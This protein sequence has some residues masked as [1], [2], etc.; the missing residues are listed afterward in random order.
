MSENKS[1]FNLTFFQLL[2]PQKNPIVQKPVKE[3]FVRDNRPEELLHGPSVDALPV[4]GMEAAQNRRN[5]NTIDL[6]G[7]QLEGKTAC[8]AKL[9]VAVI[10]SVAYLTVSPPSPIFGGKGGSHRV[11]SCRRLPSGKLENLKKLDPDGND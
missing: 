11:K 5:L 8:I 6:F 4:G 9:F 1:V 3:V 7:G 2:Y 10:C